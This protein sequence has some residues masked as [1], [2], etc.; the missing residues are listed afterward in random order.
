MP[1]KILFLTELQLLGH[2]FFISNCE[3][4]SD[5][6]P[7]FWKISSRSK[8]GL[9]WWTLYHTV[10]CQNPETDEEQIL[11]EEALRTW[12]AFLCSGKL[13]PSLCFDNYAFLLNSCF[14]NRGKIIKYLLC[15]KVDLFYGTFSINQMFLPRN[16]PF[17]TRLDYS[18]STFELI[19]AKGSLP[20]WLLSNSLSC[21]WGTKLFKKRN[22]RR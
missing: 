15:Q 2:V 3:W 19:N 10:A 17:K 13:P 12:R 20:F 22:R 11:L 21:Y 8:P 18:Y 16:F 5:F 6:I 4:C 7:K 1:Q 14:G 9:L